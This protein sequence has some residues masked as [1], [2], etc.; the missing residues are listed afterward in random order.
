MQTP[1]IRHKGFIGSN[2]YGRVYDPGLKRQVSAH[3]FA[4]GAKPGD[5]PVL[6]ACDHKWCVNPKHLSF[7]TQRQ[8]VHDAIERGLF[9]EYWSRVNTECP[10]GHTYED[11]TY[12]MRKGNN[13]KLHRRCLICHRQSAKGYYAKKKANR[14]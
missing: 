2:G 13:G 6:H 8:N 10:N 9:D 11:G 7:G 3:R 4:I 5:P 12:S 14:T 1:C